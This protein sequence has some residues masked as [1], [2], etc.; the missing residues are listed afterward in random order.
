MLNYL[1]LVVAVIIILAILVG[2][3]VFYLY[4]TGS[5]F[6]AFLTR[7]FSGKD[8]NFIIAYPPV[9]KPVDKL[10]TAFVY[11]PLLDYKRDDGLFGNNS[12]KGACFRQYE[13]GIGYGNITSLFSQ[14]QK[15]ACDN[16]NKDMPK[17][18][19]LSSNTV[20]SDAMGN[21]AR[22]ECDLWD[23]EYGDSRRSQRYIKDQ[24][25]TD[26][27]WQGIAENSQKILMSYL[28]V[29]CPATPVK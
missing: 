8:E 14:Y 27:Q 28:R 29:Y 25:V 5:S 10:F 20:D 22:L 7:I 19:I 15:A 9:P 2:G 21:Y 6:P 11:L 23:K 16:Q 17:P 13:I 4:Q 1:K 12:I 26:G 18:Q 24:L 3:G